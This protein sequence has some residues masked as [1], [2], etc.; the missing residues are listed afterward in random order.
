MPSN[1]FVRRR[2][3]VSAIQGSFWP[4]NFRELLGTE[5]QRHVVPTWHVS[6]AVLYR[7]LEVL[8][9]WQKF[10]FTSL[11]LIAVPPCSHELMSFQNGFNSSASEIVNLPPIYATLNLPKIQSFRI[12]KFFGMIPMTRMI[13]AQ[14]V[15]LLQSISSHLGGFSTDQPREARI[16][17]NTGVSSPCSHTIF[18]YTIK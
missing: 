3:Q 4:R 8:H 17:E 18:L 5:S 9:V 16:C 2:L 13:Q 6:R 7:R 12:W 11:F 1:V 10:I 14:A 15:S